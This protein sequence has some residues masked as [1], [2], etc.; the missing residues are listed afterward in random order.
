MNTATS[1]ELRHSIETWLF[2]NGGSVLLLQVGE[3]K[4][5]PAFSQPITGGVKPGERA[6][7]AGVR[8]I[9]EETSLSVDPGDLRRVVAGLAVPIDDYR[10]V[11]KTVFW[12][13]LSVVS[14]TIR[15]N[16]EEH[17]AAGWEPIAGVEPRLMWESNLW[18]W[19]LTYAHRFAVQNDDCRRSR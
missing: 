14:P 1:P 16:P 6:T 18:T 15:V 8:E 17:K 5:H 3:N 11:V 19:R 9:R 12:L 2:D 13:Q 4:R 7:E 10:I